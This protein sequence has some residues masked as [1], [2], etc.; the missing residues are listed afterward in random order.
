[1]QTSKGSEKALMAHL[2]KI[3]HVEIKQVWEKY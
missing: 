3:E 1:M 2:L